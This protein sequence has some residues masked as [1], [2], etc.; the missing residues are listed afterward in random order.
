MMFSFF[1]PPFH[2]DTL[3]LEI[4]DTITLRG[5]KATTHVDAGSDKLSTFTVK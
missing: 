2:G 5:M 4:P 1:S 3:V